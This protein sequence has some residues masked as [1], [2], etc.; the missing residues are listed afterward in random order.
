MVY[1]NLFST[2]SD[3]ARVWVYPVDTELASEDAS[4]VETSLRQFI[5]NWHSHG[6]KVQADATILFDR[7]I[8]IGAEIPEAEI[9]GCGIDASVHAVESIGSQSGFSILTG[10][11]IFFRNEQNLIQHASRSEFRTLVRNGE[12]S[13]NTLVLDPSITQISQL[14]G[15]GFELPAR[16]SWHATVFRIPTEIT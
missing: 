13:G 5:H 4:K 8:V 15:G 9:S 3:H 7:F 16:A 12:I 14:R 6:R 10:L 11:T 2:L 1:N